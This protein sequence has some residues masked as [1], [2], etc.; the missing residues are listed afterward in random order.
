MAMC[1]YSSGPHLCKR[2]SQQTCESGSLIMKGSTAISVLSRIVQMVSI[3]E[4]LCSYAIPHSVTQ[5]LSHYVLSMHT[6]TGV[7]F[8][9]SPFTNSVAHRETSDVCREGSRQT[10]LRTR[11]MNDWISPQIKAII[12]SIPAHYWIF[13]MFTPSC[14]S[15]HPNGTR[16]ILKD[17]T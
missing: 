4:W 6:A 9:W 10:S 3:S 17:M 15:S 8:P 12:T 5:T 16:I 11:P 2:S 14:G 1:D 13:T 7:A